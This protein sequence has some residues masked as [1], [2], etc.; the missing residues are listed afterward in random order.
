MPLIDD[1]HAAVTET[2]EDMWNNELINS[3]ILLSAL[4]SAIYAITNTNIQ[5][6]ELDTGQTKQ[7]VTRADLQALIKQRETLLDSICRLEIS[8]G[9]GTPAIKQVG[10]YW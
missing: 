4:N 1:D 8:L 7:R 2:I 3:C 10:G 5:S 9:V 6:Y